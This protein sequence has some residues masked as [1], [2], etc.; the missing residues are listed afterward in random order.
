[1]ASETFSI[2]YCLRNKK[3][4][5]VQSTNMLECIAAFRQNA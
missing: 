3:E 4:S 1:M 5:D 2:G